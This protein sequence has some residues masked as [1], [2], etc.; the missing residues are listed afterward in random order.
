MKMFESRITQAG[1]ITSTIAKHF[2]VFYLSFLG[3]WLFMPE[4]I[5]SD[6]GVYDLVYPP[7]INSLLGL[8]CLVGLIFV[9]VL[10][11]VI[12]VRRCHDINLS[13][14]YAVIM[15]IPFNIIYFFTTYDVGSIILS[16]IPFS[17]IIYLS[18]RDGDVGPN[19]YGED[20]KHR[21]SDEEFEVKSLGNKRYISK[22]RE[23]VYGR[24]YGK[25][26]RIS[27][28]PKGCFEGF[29]GL[30]PECEK[31]FTFQIR[32]IEGACF[33]MECPHC[34]CLLEIE[35]TPELNENTTSSSVSGLHMQCD[36]CGERVNN[37]TM[38]C[39][40][41]CNN[42]FCYKHRLPENHNCDLKSTWEEYAREQ[43]IWKHSNSVMYEHDGEYNR[44]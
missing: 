40:I 22:K 29:S 38:W 5:I 27:C 7:A 14:W 23:E 2:L 25:V 18:I 30:C 1:M 9:Y 11:I 13:G 41:R 43:S 10:Y 44:I 36:F 3:L 6:L 12:V 31:S 26:G 42:S 4:I 39:C 17:F 34:G 21:T 24:P 16:L 8:F 28:G 15:L 37:L 20:P 32:K 33:D 19:K 35:N